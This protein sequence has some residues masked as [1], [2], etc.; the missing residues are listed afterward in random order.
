MTLGSAPIQKSTSYLALNRTNY[1][2][3]ALSE[4]LALCLAG[5]PRS[6]SHAH[7]GGLTTR[8]SHINRCFSLLV[9]ITIT[10]NKNKKVFI[11]TSQHFWSLKTNISM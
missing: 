2:K 5:L 9:N 1:G 6:S 11:S 8:L 7:D 3:N 10:P 4:A